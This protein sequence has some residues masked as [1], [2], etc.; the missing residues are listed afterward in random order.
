MLHHINVVT[1]FYFVMYLWCR[2]LP[3]FTIAPLS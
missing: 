1:R 2:I 3:P